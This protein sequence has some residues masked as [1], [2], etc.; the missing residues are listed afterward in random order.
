MNDHR[1]DLDEN[2]KDNFVIDNDLDALT[3]ERERSLVP[4][5]VR[6][7]RVWEIVAVLVEATVSVRE[8]L[9]PEDVGVL[10]REH[11]F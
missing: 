5:S 4:D 11:V 8:L 7:P 3:G 6:D 2:V 10:E 9:G 1:T